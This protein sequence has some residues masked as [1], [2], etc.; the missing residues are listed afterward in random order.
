MVNL[1]FLVFILFVIFN[2]SITIDLNGGVIM[3]KVMMTLLLVMHVVFFLSYFI[4]SGIIFLTTYF[5]LIFCI[6][7]FILGISYHFSIV[8]EKHDKKT[9]FR[10]LAMTLSTFSL[11]NFFFILYITFID[12]FI[13]LEANQKLDT[14]FKFF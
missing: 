2:L 8:A 3:Q 7:T 10:I 4:H 14:I 12:P 9:S 1:L 13:Y 6:I 5:W 11:F